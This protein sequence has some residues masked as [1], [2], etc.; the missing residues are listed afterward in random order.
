MTG[1]GYDRRR[2]AARIAA[3][4][5]LPFGALG[6]PLSSAIAATP[7][8]REA[9]DGDF[10]LGRVLTRELGDGAAIVV[11]RR[12]RIHFAA[13]EGGMVVGGEQVFAEVAAPPVLAPLATLEKTRATAHIFPL[14][15]DP[16]G[17]I[18]GNEREMDAAHLLHAIETGQAMVAHG[19]D[20]EARAKDAKTF[21]AQLARMGAEA[22][23]TLPRDLFYPAPTRNSAT[24][25]LALPGG[26]DGTISVITDAS[27][28]AGSGLLRASERAIMTR[29]GDSTR[30]AKEGWS[31]APLE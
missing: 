23:S 25:S 1:R 18:T 16:L 5:L 22:V 31:L 26:D 7:R 13:A 3:A 9:P 29:I 28:Q 20:G 6:T 15:L 17:H 27:V 4:A 10:L 19:P 11:T 21:L 2:V 12:W 24:R 14:R 8:S 30:M